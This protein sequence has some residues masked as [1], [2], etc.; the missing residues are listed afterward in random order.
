ML[1]KTCSLLLVLLLVISTTSMVFARED[2][3]DTHKFTLVT[4]VTE[5]KVTE[6]S[7]V[8]IEN[9]SLELQSGVIKPYDIYGYETFNKKSSKFQR[10]TLYA[11]DVLGD[12]LPVGTHDITVYY[13]WTETWEVDK[14]GAKIRLIS[15]TNKVIYDAIR[16]YHSI[17]GWSI[18]ETSWDEGIG[19][20][21]ARGTGNVTFVQG[22]TEAWTHTA[23]VY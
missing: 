8:S 15:S 23:Y 22:G 2:S 9:K 12:K 21:K 18:N 5:E 14:Y 11:M 20:N 17:V 6:I 16:D 1:R 7:E 19:T 4:E 3:S 10:L 13:E